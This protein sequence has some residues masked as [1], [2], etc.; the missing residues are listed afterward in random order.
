MTMGPLGA[1]VGRH[2]ETEHTGQAPEGSRRG[3]FAGRSGLL[4]PLLLAAASTW[5]LVGNA[6]MPVPEGTDFP[7]PRFYPTLLAVAG[8][9]LAALLTV[10]YLRAPEHPEQHSEKTYAW[11]TDWVS[12][13]WCVGGFLA[14]ALLLAP[15]GW[16]LAAALLFWCVARGMGSRRPLFDISVAL[17]VS[18]AIY[19]AFAVALGLPL[20]SGVLGGW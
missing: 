13:A 4:F 15:L 18:S 2:S 16:I 20:P 7:G 6:T 17:L 3:F 12:V 14:F 19:L 8:Y 10:Q 5:I 1:H 9:V 11:F